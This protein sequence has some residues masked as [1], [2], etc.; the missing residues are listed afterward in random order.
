MRMTVVMLAVSNLRHAA[1]R[2]CFTA[3]TSSLLL[4]WSDRVM[5]KCSPAAVTR[6]RRLNSSFKALSF[7]LGAFQDGIGVAD[8]VGERFVRDIVESIIVLSSLSHDS[9][10]WLWL[11]PGRKL[12]LPLGSHFWYHY[13]MAKSIRGTKKKR[14]RPKTTGTG[15][16]IGMRWQSAELAAIDAWRGRQEDQLSRADAIRRLV[17]LGLKRS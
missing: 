14:G 17:A 5:V 9:T 13:S 8:R 4:T 11:E 16:Q 12:P 2:N 15:S 10:S 6:P 7:R 3:M 1:P